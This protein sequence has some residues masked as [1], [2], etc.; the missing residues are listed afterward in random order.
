MENFFSGEAEKIIQQLLAERKEEV[1][2]KPLD[3]A[4]EKE[5]CL[6]IYGAKFHFH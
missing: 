2:N 4:A 3:E 1:M 6:K 5:I